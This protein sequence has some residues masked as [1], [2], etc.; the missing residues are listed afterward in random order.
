MQE[1]VKGTVGALFALMEIFLVTGGNQYL[2]RRVE[3]VWGGRDDLLEVLPQPAFRFAG[4]SWMD[5]FL[6]DGLF[7]SLKIQF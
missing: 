6:C 2:V 7:K 1:F 4:L 5:F 3:Y